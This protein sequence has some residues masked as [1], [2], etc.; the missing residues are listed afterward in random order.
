MAGEIKWLN[1]WWNNSNPR[2][3]TS[4]YLQAVRRLGA[5]PLVT[6]SDPGMENYGITNAHTYM[7]HVLDSTLSDTLQH[8][9][10]RK[11][12]NIKP[13]IL[14]PAEFNVSDF[15]IPVPPELLEDV[16]RQWAPSAH[17]M[18]KCAPG[19]I[20]CKMVEAFTTL[21]SPVVSSETFWPIY[22]QV[23][24]Y[25]LAPEYNNT[26]DIARLQAVSCSAPQS[27]HNGLCR[28]L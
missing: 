18:F 6:Q 8:R 15:K 23:V 3:I 19:Y 27:D 22:L 4:Y 24:Q 7:R 21:G 12:M 17:P 26:E 16:E 1:I 25:M 20:E 28:A 14:C 9:W 5:I 13:E 10:M 11:H 2:L